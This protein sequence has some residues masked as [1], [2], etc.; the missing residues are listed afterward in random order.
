MFLY[1]KYLHLA[2][3]AGHA[4]AASELGQMMLERG[5]MDKARAILRRAVSLGKTIHNTT[6][7][8]C[9]LAVIKYDCKSLFYFI[10]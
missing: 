7:S 10:G 6:V 9:R 2:S 1:V 8:F 4:Q 3:N 5:K